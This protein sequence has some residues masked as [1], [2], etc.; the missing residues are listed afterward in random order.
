[1]GE[2]EK[3]EIVRKPSALWRLQLSRLR[4]AFGKSLNGILDENSLLND[5]PRD[6]IECIG[7]KIE[8]AA[9]ENSLRN[10]IEGSIGGGKKKKSKSKKKRRKTK[11]K[12]H[13]T[14]R[15]KHKSKRRK[16]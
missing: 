7:E 10:D 2:K 1:M 16:S 5:V 11:R 8:I 14:K 9:S 3:F 13:K 15:K 6:I 4:L 12:K